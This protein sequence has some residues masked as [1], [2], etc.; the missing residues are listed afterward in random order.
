VDL[1]VVKPDEYGAA[2]LYFTGSREHNVALRGLA[3]EKGLKINE[4][5]VFRGAGG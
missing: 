5:G 2:L 4:Y 1:R 3:H